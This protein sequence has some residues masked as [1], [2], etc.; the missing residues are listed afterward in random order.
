MSSEPGN[1]V[2]VPFRIAR[3]AIPVAVAVRSTLLTA[4][5]D[6]LKSRGRF[7]D[8]CA[9]LPPELRE[10]MLFG[11]AGVW[12][13]MKVASAHYAAVDALGFTDAETVD[14]GRSVG[15]RLNSTLLGVVIKLAGQAGATPWVPLAQTGKLFERVFRGGGL[16]VERLGPK[17]ARIEVVGLPL[18]SSPYFRGALRGQVRAGCELFCKRAYAREVEPRSVLNAGAL[19]VSWV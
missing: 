18:M 16:Q 13:P 4:S 6:A 7:D 15:G 14:N 17:E 1:R 10:S 9:L 3:D 12:L 2:L 8:Y 5:I 11:V 19:R